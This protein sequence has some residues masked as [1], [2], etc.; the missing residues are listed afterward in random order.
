MPSSHR[1]APLLS[2][3]LLSALL[4]CHSYAAR[5]QDIE[6][7][8]WTTVGAVGTVDEADR[9]KVVINNGQVMM[10]PEAMGTVHLRY[11]VVAVD[12]LFGVPGAELGVLYSDDGPEAQVVVRLKRVN[13]VTGD[14]TTLLTLN[15]NNF[16][17]HDSLRLH[18]DFDCS[19]RFDFYNNAYFIEGTLTKTADSGNPVLAVIQLRGVSC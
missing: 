6:R 19:L 17:A 1:F 7:K 11:N 10:K 16:D 14:I 2:L 9:D 18:T 4:L 3:L 8:D 13:I 5:A 12:G 15:S